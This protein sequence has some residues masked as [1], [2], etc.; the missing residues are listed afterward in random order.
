MVQRQEHKLHSPNNHNLNFN[1]K[2]PRVFLHKL[3]I[4]TTIMVN[5]CSSQSS[6]IRPSH[7]QPVWPLLEGFA[8]HEHLGLVVDREHTSACNTTKDVGTSTLEK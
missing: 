7:L 6:I 8:K 4:S 1:L 2:A 3:Q 5:Y